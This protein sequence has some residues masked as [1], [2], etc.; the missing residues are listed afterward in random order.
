M[1]K[2]KMRTA[3]EAAIK[4]LPAGTGFDPF[5]HTTVADLCWIC[6][7][8]LDMHAES[9][10]YAPLALRRKYLK[11]CQTNGYYIAEAEKEFRICLGVRK[12]D[13]YI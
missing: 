11:F 6:L 7:H 4:K 13:C 1:T 3:F 2:T 8:E 5:A 10:N 12:S 9:E